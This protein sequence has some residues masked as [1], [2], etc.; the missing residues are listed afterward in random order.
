MKNYVPKIRFASD[1]SL[2]GKYIFGNVKSGIVDSVHIS[3]CIAQR[4]VSIVKIE[5]LESPI[6][7]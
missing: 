4:L 1:D 6:D 3:G 5:F 2:S 7:I